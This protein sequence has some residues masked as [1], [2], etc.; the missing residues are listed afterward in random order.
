MSETP[1]GGSRREGMKAWFMRAYDRSWVHYDRLLLARPALSLLA[2]ALLS[3]FFLYHIKDFRLDASGDTLVLE[4]DEDLRYYRQMSSRYESG[5]YAIITYTPPEGLFSQVAL[6]RL[7]R[8]RADL[9]KLGRVSSVVSILDVPLL[10]NPPGTLKELKEN[11]KTLE[12]PKARMDYAVE[13]FRNSP[14]YRN[15]LVGEAMKTSAVIV[16]FQV[17]KAAQA[18]AARRLVLREKRYKT[19][20]TTEEETELDE[21]EVSYRQYKDDSAVRR[22]ED[23]TAIRGI[24]ARYQGEAQLFLGG[25]PMIVEDI[26]RYV[27]SDIIVFGLGM[28]GFVVLT[29][30]WIYR[31]PRWVFLPMLTCLL[32]VLVMMGGIGLIRWEVT[33]VSSNFVSL[34]IIL[35][36]S[37]AIHI[38]SHYREL[39]QRKPKASNR[40]LVLESA[41][42]TIVP[43]MYCNL[44]TIAGF[45][46]LILCDILPVTQFGWMM[47]VGLVVSMVLVFWL[48]PSAMAL[49][50]KPQAQEEFEW[51]APA[52]FNFARVVDHHKTWVYAGSLV[53]AVLTTVGIAKLQV[54]NSFINYFKKS[55]PIYQG[56]KF[57]DEE[58]G[59]TTPLDIILKLEREKTAAPAQA[60]AAP[61]GSDEFSGFEEFEGEGKDDPRYWYTAERIATIEKVHDYAASLP[62]TGK[63]LS[64]A[65]LHKTAKSL[66]EGKTFDDFSLALLFNT[67]TGKFREL[68]I[69]PYVNVESN[70]ARVALRV[71]DSMPTLRRGEFVKRIRKDLVEKLGL[72]EDQFR[73]SG[74]M[75]LYNNMLQSLYASQIKAIAGTLAALFAMFLILFRSF[76]ISVVALMPQFLA[77]LAILG[78]MGL[79]GLPLD[80]MTITIVSISVGIGVDDAIHYVY[81]FQEEVA[82]DRNYHRAMYACHLTIG[83]AMLYTSLAITIG[84]S[85]LAL[86]KFIPTVLFGILT[87][88]AMMVACT[89]S[90]VLLPALILLVKPFGPGMTELKEHPQAAHAAEEAGNPA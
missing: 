61:A 65:T 38:V 58:L 66:N 27:R 59:G 14:I 56:M 2:L 4:H 28:L 37:L 88:V 16:N 20:L 75:L 45:N 79:A 71:K 6:D 5:D 13:E 12:D 3:G 64:L 89:S 25:I 87:G 24:I 33:V 81:R 8:L 51:G 19:D 72:R 31:S 83:N 44:T 34:Q 68:L 78:V 70:E 48:L 10:W 18:R 60:A 23:V 35:T 32:S 55:T 86:S 52:E 49:L 47:S 41:R 62:E 67:M 11:I 17:D 15:L 69:T 26:M 50:P 54:E 29:L 74:L 76:K 21:L 77:C 53:V 22:H 39:L 30:W 90:Q 36:M 7:K 40:E 9:K 46:S 73:V 43:C 42:H 80:V 57:I 1:A 85:I 82:K 63:V 84:F